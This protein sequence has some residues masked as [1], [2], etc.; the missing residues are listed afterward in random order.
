MKL[1][2]KT[3][4]QPLCLHY[5]AFWAISKVFCQT[6]RRRAQRNKCYTCEGNV[7]K[8]VAS[9]GALRPLRRS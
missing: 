6:Q 4:P 2:P 3:S 5:F 8:N 7:R 1:R 9:E